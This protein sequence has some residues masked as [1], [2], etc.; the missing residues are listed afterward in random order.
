MRQLRPYNT[1]RSTPPSSPVTLDNHST[2]PL[3]AQIEQLLMEQI[4]TGVLSEGTP[5][6]SEQELARFYKVSRMTARQAL[7]GL[8]ANGYVVS[9]RRKGTFVTRPK[10]EKTFLRLQGF[11]QEMLARGM[12]PSS[13]VL[14]HRI[15]HPPD[16]VLESLRLEPKAKV[17]K[18]RRLRF[19]DRV[20]IAVENSYI[21]T[22]SFPGIDLIDFSK[23]SLYSTFIN[24]YRCHIG[25]SEDIIEAS[26]ATT[27]EA[28]LLT[29]PRGFGILSITRL[30][31]SSEGQPVE[32]GRS[33]YRSDRYRA[34]IRIP[35]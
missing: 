12:R 27:E 1:S 13:T 15:I 26:K 21:P 17:F 33:R 2:T 28:R 10:I 9:I 5:L 24:Q 14:E 6:Q 11:S 7:H 34:V 30:V 19:A 32:L 3:Y 4:K 31:M 23:E 8:K 25:W 35:R 18:L 20:P 22:D 16:D 29:I